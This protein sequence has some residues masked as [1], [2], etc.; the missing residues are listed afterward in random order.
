M[1]FS[2]TDPDD[3]VGMSS[4]SLAV[5]YSLTIGVGGGVEGIILLTATCSDSRS[6]RNTRESRNDNVCQMAKTE[7]ETI[8][9]TMPGRDDAILLDQGR[10]SP[11]PK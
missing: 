10:A 3:F 8:K 4:A 1:S 5:T 2:T 9:R 7:K 6:A 11:F